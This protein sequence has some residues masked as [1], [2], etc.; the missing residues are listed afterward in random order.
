MS[1]RVYVITDPD[2]TYGLARI[3]KRRWWHRFRR[4][5]SDDFVVVESCRAGEETLVRLRTDDES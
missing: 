4:R 5:R 3:P 1:D 2:A